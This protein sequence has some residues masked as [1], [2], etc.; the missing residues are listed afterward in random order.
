[1]EPQ[2]TKANLG[3]LNQH[4]GNRRHVGPTRRG[5]AR[6]QH[7]LFD[8]EMLL[9]LLLPEQCPC[10]GSRSPKPVPQRRS[11]KP[12][13]TT[14]LSGGRPQKRTTTELKSAGP[15]NPPGSVQVAARAALCGVMISA[16]STPTRLPALS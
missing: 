13:S 3:V 10:L 14:E 2:G 16:F 1:L 5:K 12:S 11:T 7:L 8:A 15:V 6:Q 4:P 9:A